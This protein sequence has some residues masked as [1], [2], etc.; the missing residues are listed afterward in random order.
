MSVKEQI[1]ALHNLRADEYRRHA[2]AI[3]ALD[4]QIRDLQK[5]CE[6]DQGYTFTADPSGNADSFRE[7]NVC[8]KEI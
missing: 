5:T 2:V 3:V 8:G 1:Q 4:R 6:H 7:C